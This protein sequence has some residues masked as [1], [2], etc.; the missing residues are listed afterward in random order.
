M[1]IYICIYIYLYVYIY[2]CIYTYVYIYM[3]IYIYVWMDLLADCGFKPSHLPEFGRWTSTSPSD[4]DLGFSSSWGS[5]E[6]QGNSGPS[7][8]RNYRFLWTMDISGP[9]LNND[10][11]SKWD[12]SKGLNSFFISHCQE[13]FKK[14]LL[15]NGRD[16]GDTHR[17][18][19]AMDYPSV[20]TGK[21]QS[22]G[23][24]VYQPGR[25]NQIIW[26]C[27]LRLFCYVCKWLYMSVQ[28]HR[29]LLSIVAVI[30]WTQNVCNV[31][32]ENMLFDYVWLFF[33]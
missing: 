10:L 16:M 14:R 9:I 20:R 23:F 24:T 22:S 18:C 27:C 5:P 17:H 28:C 25:L 19:L 3:Y 29:P 2:I 33:V 11:V 15:Y 21:Q 30:A 31:R 8:H 32:W 26:S 7:N 12:S 1:Y 13:N 4:F 6:Y